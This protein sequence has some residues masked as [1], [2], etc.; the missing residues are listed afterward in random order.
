MSGSEERMVNGLEENTH[1]HKRGTGGFNTED[2]VWWRLMKVVFSFTSYVIPIH[3]KDNPLHYTNDST[4][5]L[6]VTLHIA[7]QCIAQWK[8][9]GVVIENSQKSFK[10]CDE[11]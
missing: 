1:A 10:M 2:C 8:I 5:I 4:L 11:L 6:V 9:I 7:L 3:Q